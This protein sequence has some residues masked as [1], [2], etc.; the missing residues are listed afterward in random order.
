MKLAHLL[1][2]MFCAAALSSYSAK[3]QDIGDRFYQAIRSND[4]VAVRALAT[5]KAVNTPDSHGTTP[6][7]C[8]AA[9]GSSETLKL[10]LD[11][12]A[13]PNAKNAFGASALMWAAGD[14]TKVRLLLAKGAEVNARSNFGRTPLLLATLHDGSHDIAQLLID[15]GADVS[16][17]DKAKI[18]VLEA[19][20]QGNDSATVRLVLAHGADAKAKDATGTTALMWAAM[21]GNIETTK[22]LLEK[23]SDINAV[24]IESFERVKN[25]PL[26]LGS[27]TPLISA[28][29]YGPPE[30]VKLLIDAGANVNARD[31]RGMTPLML[32]V[33]TDRPD[34]R[35][36]KL[37]LARGADAS[38]RSKHGET[39]FDW[40]K[41]FR[42]PEVF[43][44]LGM[45]AAATLTAVPIAAATQQNNADVKASVEKSLALL[46][47][48]NGKFIN[49]GGC[50]SCHAQNLTGVAVSAGRT[51]GAKVD[52][53]ADG[54][55]ARA[56]LLFRGSGEE[57][58]LQLL[59]P[60]GAVH[61]TEYSVLQ[62]GASH[63]PPSPAIDALVLYIAAEQGAAGN[64][65]YSAG[66]NP[67]PPIEDGD[68]F[69]T[70]MGVRCLQLY[71][72][73]GRKAEF[74]DRIRRAGMWLKNAEPRSTED[75]VMQ[76]LG[77]RWANVPTK[78]QL[79]DLLALQREDGGWAQTPWL[80]SDAYATGQV[81][82]ALHES[83]VT[84]NDPAYARGVAYLQST[85]KADGSWR[86]KSRAP[87]FQPYFQ[88]GFPYDDDQ[89][90][91]E[92]GTAWAA[93][94]MGYAIPSGIADARR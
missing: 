46:Q 75:R 35:I 34:P 89:W 90:I 52:E 60:P 72:I 36:T 8:A 55:M 64:W 53:Q 23:G 18:C 25:G 10:L 57:M 20:A 7:M 1:F 2:P 26:E 32:A 87:K 61:T 82:F 11:R 3:A 83:S 48:T 66:G 70:A 29:P 30:L 63:I 76:L 13:D 42:N 40:A 93:M 9:V 39:A 54:E 43:K 69:S 38:I 12:G 67:R 91:S 45:P 62:L 28:L 22:L 56:T 4:I 5:T 21:N 78:P 24:T 84:A 27:F 33:S 65:H 92:A 80:S 17:C 71:S 88:S 73:P 59:D 58:F 77:L 79:H 74:E 81:L 47:R 14:I 68:F 85:Q 50:I 19:A 37:L 41:K 44:A 51:N 94:G 16:A 86:V 49:T 15:K 31:T 6:L